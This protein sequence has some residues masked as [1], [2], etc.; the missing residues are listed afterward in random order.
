MEPVFS[1]DKDTGEPPP[2]TSGTEHALLCSPDTRLLDNKNGEV[3]KAR[4]V[5]GIIVTPV[6]AGKNP[7]AVILSIEPFNSR[8][9]NKN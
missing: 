5:S 8:L 3:D 2:F 9:L 7:A 1:P 4:I 6:A